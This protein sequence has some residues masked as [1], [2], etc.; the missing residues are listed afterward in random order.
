MWREI[1]STVTKR[2]KNNN[3]EATGG[4]GQWG[5]KLEDEN[6]GGSGE[7]RQREHLQSGG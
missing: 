7:A 6:G 4:N 2:I 5:F 1:Y 3:K